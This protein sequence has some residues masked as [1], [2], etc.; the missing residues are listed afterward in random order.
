MYKVCFLIREGLTFFWLHQMLYFWYCIFNCL[1]DHYENSCKELF[2]ICP[3]QECALKMKRRQVQFICG[4]MM[5][6][7][8]SNWEVEEGSNLVTIFRWR[9]C[10]SLFIS[11]TSEVVYC[12][13]VAHKYIRT[14]ARRSLIGIRATIT[15]LTI[16]SGLN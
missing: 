2:T 13:S 15:T 4:Q 16:Y 1:Q 10:L 14:F 12:S 11:S 8:F 3:H 5:D 9:V 6:S 7:P